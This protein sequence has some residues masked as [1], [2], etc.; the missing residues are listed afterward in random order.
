M[1][2]PTSPNAFNQNPQIEEK[3]LQNEHEKEVLKHDFLKHILS[4]S[5]FVFVIVVVVTI[6]A[7]IVTFTEEDTDKTIKVWGVLSPIISTYLGYAI[8]GGGSKEKG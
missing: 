5:T 8:G 6:A 7:L 3:K 4:N 2:N 1:N